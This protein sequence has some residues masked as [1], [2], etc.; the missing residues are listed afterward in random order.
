MRILAIDPALNEIGIT[1]YDTNTGTIL[2]SKTLSHKDKDKKA[3]TKDLFNKKIINVDVIKKDTEKTDKEKATFMW[4]SK[5]LANIFMELNDII[6]DLKSKDLQLDLIVTETQLSDDCVKCVSIVNLLSSIHNCLI[7][8][9]R[10]TTWKKILTG[11]GNIDEDSLE[12]IVKN[13]INQPELTKYIS[14]H[15][16]DAFG[17][18]L[19]YLKYFDIKTPHVRDMNIFYE[20]RELE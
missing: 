1:A 19:T 10:P 20:K 5:R 17:L 9:F 11:K 6:K 8:E 14:E 16:I 7:Y 3:F 2:L 13:S 12:N 18:I 15:E 4:T